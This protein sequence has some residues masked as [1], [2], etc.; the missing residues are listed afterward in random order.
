[1]YD[2]DR[3]SLKNKRTRATSTEA[4]AAM[5]HP[6]QL[7]GFKSLNCTMME[8]I[9]AGKR[10]VATNIIIIV[11]IQSCTC[12]Y[13]NRIMTGSVIRLSVIMALI[14]WFIPRICGNQ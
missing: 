3:N 7:Y 1:M 9:A 4:S 5:H 6:G 13:K 10:K 12:I 11:Y 14:V 8:V 2:V